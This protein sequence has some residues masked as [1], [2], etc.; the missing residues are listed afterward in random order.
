VVVLDILRPKIS[1]RSL[2][3]CRQNLRGRKAFQIA[4][5]INKKGNKIIALIFLKMI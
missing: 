3:T 4:S 5:G 2:E 1:L